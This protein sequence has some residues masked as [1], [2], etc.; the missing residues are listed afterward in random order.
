MAANA[1]SVEDED[2]SPHPIKESALPLYDAHQEL[3]A[4]G[5]ANIDGAFRAVGITF[6]DGLA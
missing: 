4:L 6:N 1:E 5:T 3:L 2:E